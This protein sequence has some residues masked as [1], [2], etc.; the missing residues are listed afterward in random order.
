MNNNL[1]NNYYII[2]SL[3]LDKNYIKKNLLYE[4]INISLVSKEINII[5]N[6]NLRYIIH[7]EILNEILTYSYIDFKY[8][9]YIKDDKKT[10]FSSIQYI[11][12]ELIDCYLKKNLIH[13]NYYKTYINSLI[14]DKFYP[15]NKYIRNNY[16]LYKEIAKK[17]NNSSVLKISLINAEAPK[18]K[19]N[20]LLNK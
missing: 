16:S 3:V 8:L 19:L 17:I 1:S 10:L 6:N 2:F 18:T 4:Y 13:T 5:F 9:S 20:I 11:S 15:L 14:Y 7:S 12:D